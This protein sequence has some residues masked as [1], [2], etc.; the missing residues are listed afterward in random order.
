MSYHFGIARLVDVGE[1]DE[2]ERLLLRS[3]DILV[4]LGARREEAQ[5]RI[6]L[7]VAFH[8][9]GALA[10]AAAQYAKA[11]PLLQ[12]LGDQDKIAKVLT[13]FGEVAY[14]S[15]DLDE[16]AKKYRQAL[17]L[18]AGEYPGEEAYQRYRLG[19]S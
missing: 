13:N 3:L 14:Q 12:A 16:A 11:L 8:E 7:G 15:G 19:R 9:A 4:D 10:R 5:A 2:A 1:L 17:A 6:N 18:A